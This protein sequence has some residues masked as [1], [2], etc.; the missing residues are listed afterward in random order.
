MKRINPGTGS[1]KTARNVD[2]PSIANPTVLGDP[3]E[4][5][6]SNAASAHRRSLKNRLLSCL[7]WMPTATVNASKAT[8]TID[9]ARFTQAGVTPTTGSGSNS[10]QS[11]GPPAAHQ[12]RR[13]NRDTEMLACV[14]RQRIDG[15]PPSVGEHFAHQLRNSMQCSDPKSRIVLLTRLKEQIHNTA[16]GIQV[17]RSD[18]VGLLQQGQRAIVP[19][20]HHRTLKL[21]AV[22]YA[23]VEAQLSEWQEQQMLAIRMC[24]LRLPDP[25]ASK[26]RLLLRE[27][28]TFHDPTRRTQLLTQMAEQI[29][30]HLVK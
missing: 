20:T 10:F 28:I 27:V 8:N 2:T 18:S 5:S 25:L 13:G 17:S 30:E 29:K 1:F 7:G 22:R 23:G 19:P 14:I 26:Y 9:A 16:Q 24:L 6:V 3:P 4:A 11:S 15:L 21:V 12:L